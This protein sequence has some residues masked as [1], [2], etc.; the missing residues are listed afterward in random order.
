MAVNSTSA[1]DQTRDKPAVDRPKKPASP[2]NAFYHK[3]GPGCGRPRYNRQLVARDEML[4]LRNL[5]LEKPANFA[6]AKSKEAVLAA[7]GW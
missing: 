1:A 2:R 5:D 7:I 3:I 4:N 6:E